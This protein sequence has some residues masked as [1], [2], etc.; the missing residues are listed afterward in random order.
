MTD[1]PSEMAGASNPFPKNYPAPEAEPASDDADEIFPILFEKDYKDFR[2]IPEEDEPVVPK[3]STVQAFV[4]TQPSVTGLEDVSADDL[5]S[6][7]K[8]DA[9][10]ETLTPPDSGSQTS[11][12]GG[13]TGKK[14]PS[15]PNPA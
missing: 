12:P 10:K 1:T 9:P 13:S 5:E 3:V 11:S 15:V 14:K 4:T 2:G 7:A 8:K 6:P